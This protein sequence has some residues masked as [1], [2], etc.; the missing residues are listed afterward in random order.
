M[1]RSLYD[2]IQENPEAKRQI[3]I[4][5]WF[6]VIGSLFIIIVGLITGE[7]PNPYLIPGLLVIGIDGVV[8]GISLLLY[9]RQAR[10]AGWLM[11]LGC[12]LFLSSLYLFT[13]MLLNPR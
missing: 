4:M 3:Q 5:S 13:R 7:H 2:R 12:G 6:A 11:L 10:I 1:K 9:L 8:I